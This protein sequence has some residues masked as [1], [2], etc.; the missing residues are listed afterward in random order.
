MGSMAVQSA[1][2]DTSKPDT[3]L[4]PIEKPKGIMMKLAYYS[5]RRQ[6]G[7]V[8]TPLKVHSARLPMA[9][10]QFYAK[11]GRLDKKLQLPPETVMLIREQVARTNICLFCI[12]IGRSFTI[13]A[14]MN[15]AKFDALEQYRTSPLFTDA[16]RAALDYVTELTKN[17]TMGL[18]TF[19]R[20]ARHYSE[21]QICEI[22]WL[23]A[24]EHVYNLTN[25][26]LNIHSDMLCDISRKNRQ[27]QT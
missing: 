3:F 18:D 2:V 24:T 23:V 5:T 4:P 20:M 10:G 1:T 27:S 12:D 6:F 22:V 16:E 9:F 25:I 11:I 17:K 13:K 19:S 15:E 14:S 21:R 7:K 8:L 26:G